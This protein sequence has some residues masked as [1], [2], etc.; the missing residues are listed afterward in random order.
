[1]KV[2]N[3]KLTKTIT[4]N[5][6]TEEVEKKLNNLLELANKTKEAIESAVTIGAS[7]LLESP[8]EWKSGIS[9]ET[10]YAEPETWQENVDKTI[11]IL[12]KWIQE[13]V[14]DKGISQRTPEMIEA[15]AEL[16]KA[17]AST[18]NLLY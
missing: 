12:C 1:M 17:R 3:S 2:E 13:G 9:L 8:K 18:A 6:E 10:G 7:T 4:L 14:E 5:I 16:V 11:S 15:L